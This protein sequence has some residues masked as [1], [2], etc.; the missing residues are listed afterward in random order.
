MAGKGGTANTHDREVKATE[1][2]RA[3]KQAAALGGSRK[4]EKRS[5]SM[6]DV[7]DDKRR[8]PLNALNHAL[9]EEGVELAFGKKAHIIASE[10]L[11]VSRGTEMERHR[12]R[13]F[14]ILGVDWKGDF[15]VE[16]TLGLETI[17]NE[18]PTHK[19]WAFGAKHGEVLDIGK[20]FPSFLGGSP[21]WMTIGRIK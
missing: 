2:R 1:I 17:Q 20:H 5:F 10:Y 16:K 4:A 12:D 9:R 21:S 8:K 15:N 11:N 14:M 18:W 7:I 19:L 13:E 6:T 3:K